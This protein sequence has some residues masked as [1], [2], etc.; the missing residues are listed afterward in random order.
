MNIL[1]I[2]NGGREHAFA[3][4]IKQS[5]Q[6][7]HLF[8]APG[9]AGTAQIAENVAIA[10]DDF[11]KLG[12]CCLDKK[13]DLVLV[14]PEVPLVKGIR[15]YFESK[16]ELQHILLVGPGKNGAQLEGSKDFSKQF[17]L[18][19]GVPTAKARTFTAS[20]LQEALNYIDQC[21]TPI[22]LKADGLAAGK[23]VVI[24]ENLK[25]AKAEITEMLQSQ[26]F[27]AASNKVLIEEFLT[28]IE[29]SVFVLTDGTDYVILPEAKDYKRIG[30]NDTGL[31]TGGMGAVSPV[32][33][34]TPEFLKKVEEQVVK[35]TIKGLQAENIPYQ[36]FVF[37]GLM[38]VKGEPYVIEYNA[39]MGDPETQ[40]VMSRIDS[41]FVDLLVACAK[42]ELKGKELSISKNYA[43]TIVMASGGYP[44]EFQKGFPIS[45]LNEQHEANVFH[46]GTKLKE[47]SI[48]NDG[49]RVLGITATGATLA[50][51]REKAYKSALNI[52]W[53]GVTF[54]NDIGQ[55]LMK[56]SG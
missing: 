23:G 38:N 6:C 21:N 9:N 32:V 8:V 13:I 4:K 55:D 54:R 28:G 11:E 42:K 49:G 3:W 18:R 56:L 48:V 30:D 51:A 5:Q 26:K 14:G 25:E 33:F 1:I 41:D 15:D 7:D 35:P 46:A 34:A 50:E 36:G 45:G 40:S 52:G 22:V 29:L 2:G 20:A 16:K 53:E 19:H 24:A 37:I 47:N 43:L 12:Q 39:R 27:G 44:G 17:M 10:V 31:N